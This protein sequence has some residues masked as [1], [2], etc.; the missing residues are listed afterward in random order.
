[1]TTP[2]H[3]ARVVGRKARED[4]MAQQTLSLE[5]AYAAGADAANRNMRQA[6]RRAWSYEDFAIAVAELK[7]LTPFL[8][9]KD[10]FRLTGEE[11]NHDATD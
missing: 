2:S 7:R 3:C 10:S 8:P 1:M 6:G 9:P 4:D 5:M 11:P